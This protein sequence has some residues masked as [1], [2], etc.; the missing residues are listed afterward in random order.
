M[1]TS[2]KVLH[3]RL[4]HRTSG[5]ASDQFSEPRQK[6]PWHTSVRVLLQAIVREVLNSLQIRQ[7]RHCTTLHDRPS[8]DR[9]RQC[10]VW[11]AH[12]RMRLFLLLRPAHAPAPLESSAAASSCFDMSQNLTIFVRPVNGRA[13]HFA[14]LYILEKT[15]QSGSP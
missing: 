13:L 4:L 15:F 10:N 2:G 1:R 7:G 14:S 9:S 6:V 3:L 11:I 8:Q 12:R 5:K